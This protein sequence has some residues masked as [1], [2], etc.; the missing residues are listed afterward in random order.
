MTGTALALAQFGTPCPRC[1]VP[2]HAGK[3]ET[4]ARVRSEWFRCE[5]PRCSI[6]GAVVSEP[7]KVQPLVDS[8][9]QLNM[10][11][12]LEC[13]RQLR[14]VYRDYGEVRMR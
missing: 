14:K 8:F 11:A 2:M 9:R 10:P 5:N 6:I 13:I 4:S 12:R 1:G 3:T 7:N